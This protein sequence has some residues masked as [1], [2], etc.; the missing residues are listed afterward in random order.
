[1]VFGPQWGWEKALYTPTLEGLS[2]LG[3][4]WGEHVLQI[5]VEDQKGK[6][7]GGSELM[8]I[9]VATSCRVTAEFSRELALWFR[10]N[11]PRRHHE[12]LVFR[13]QSELHAPLLEALHT[14]RP[15]RVVCV[16]QAMRHVGIGMFQEFLVELLYCR[17]ILGLA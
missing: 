11:P 15:V 2:A 14:G 9:D 5:G 12:N 4:S 7:S 3:Q 6:F 17:I 13:V 8:G 16:Q 10:P 1:M